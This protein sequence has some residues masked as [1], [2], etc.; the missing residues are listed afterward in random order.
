MCQKINVNFDNVM[1]IK[2]V[3]LAQEIRSKKFASK[4][5]P[6]DISFKVFQHISFDNQN[7]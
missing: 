4:G 2:E 5:I 1:R 7:D 6:F 3:V